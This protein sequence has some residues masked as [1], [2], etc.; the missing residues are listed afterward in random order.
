MTCSA[1]VCTLQVLFSLIK[2]GLMLKLMWMIIFFC[3][4]IWTLSIKK[5]IF[6]LFY[7]NNN[8]LQKNNLTQSHNLDFTLQSV[9]KEDVLSLRVF[10]VGMMT[11]SRVCSHLHRPAL[12][13]GDRE[14]R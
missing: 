10:C 8:F 13:C 3:L 7:L 12:S 9:H 11:E 5:K 4:K 14:E 2:F 6:L 1:E